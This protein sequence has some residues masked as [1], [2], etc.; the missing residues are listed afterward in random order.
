MIHLFIALIIIHFQRQ[1]QIK[2]VVQLLEELS[3]VW[4]KTISEENVDSPF[5]PQE[6]GSKQ[7]RF[8]YERSVLNEKNIDHFQ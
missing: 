4:G 3:I 1:L 8:I 5:L 6:M 2:N 7:E